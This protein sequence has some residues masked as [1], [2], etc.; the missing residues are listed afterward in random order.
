MKSLFA[1]YI[2]FVNV[3]YIDDTV[4]PTRNSDLPIDLLGMI[5]KFYFQY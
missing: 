2:E 4:T 5:S 3:E 1:L